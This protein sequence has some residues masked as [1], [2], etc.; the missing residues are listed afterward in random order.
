MIINVVLRTLA[1]ECS[2]TLLRSLFLVRDNVDG[3]SKHE[4]VIA[5]VYV[6]SAVR[7]HNRHTVVVK[8]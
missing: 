7:A 4:D 5:I 2:C 8:H 6:A 1:R 3:L